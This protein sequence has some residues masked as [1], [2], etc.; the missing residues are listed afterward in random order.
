MDYI[1][2]NLEKTIVKIL[3]SFRVIGITGPRQSGKSTMIKQ[4][5]GDKYQ[6][7][8]FDNLELVNVFYNNPKSF[9]EK[10]NRFI[11]F[12]E[13]QNVPELFR[14]IKVL[15]DNEPD[16]KGRFI[17]TG[18]NLFTLNNN[19]SESLAGRIGLL[20]LL[21]FD[22]MEINS[23]L[24]G[25]SVFFGSYPELVTNFYKSAE[26]W[27]DSYITTYIERDVRKLQN[28]G[29]L[30]DFQRFFSLISSYTARQLNFTEIANQIGISLT[31]V[32]R[33]LSILEASYIVFLLTPY[34][35]NFSKRIT[36][37]PK[38][39]FYDTGLALYLMG[40]YGKIN[41]NS[42]VI[43]GELFENYIISESVKLNY[44]FSGQKKFYFYRTSGGKEVDLLFESG[45]ELILAE[46]KASS[47]YNPLLSKNLNSIDIPA[48]K[49]ILIY[50][51][52]TSAINESFVFQNYKD[53]LRSFA[54]G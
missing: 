22:F 35:K 54:G 17:L 1:T 51:G 52:E 32:K 16:I 7:V 28:V 31:T 26:I 38:L 10:Y 48:N 34:Y 53:Y 2:R 3:D 36:K 47:N 21:P 29:D 13:V 42:N 8:S 23:N 12:D 20:T 50:R 9:V 4:L 41:N 46:I 40:L 15:V 33:W 14:Y 19:I 25:Q 11:I 37:T 27:Y 45:N 18:S 5:L 49:R 44:H 39:Y 43:S 24:Q 30:R 6:Y